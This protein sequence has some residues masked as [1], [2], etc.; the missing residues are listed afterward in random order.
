MNRPT[1]ISPR[2]EALLQLLRTSETIWNAS[3]AFFARWELGPSQ[4]NILNVL[5]GRPD[6]CTQ[7]ELS[8]ELVTHRSN[9]TGLIVRLE[10]RGL[11]RRRDALA[12]RRAYRVTL[13]PAGQ[14]LVTEILPHYHH[15]AEQVWGKVPSAH[16]KQLVTAL[17]TL[18][19]NAEQISGDPKKVTPSHN[20]TRP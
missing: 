14:K 3:R 8:R 16:V 4:F 6:G 5:A 13:T 1:V 9:V 17:E 10:K 18:A 19:S 7:V 12:D 11:V 20:P 2:Y 15:A